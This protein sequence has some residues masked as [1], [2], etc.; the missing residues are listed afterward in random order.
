VSSEEVIVIGE[1][2]CVDMELTRKIGYDFICVLSGKTKRK[3]IEELS[4]RYDLIVKDIGNI[5]DGN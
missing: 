3:N 5:L 1:R 2:I 4:G